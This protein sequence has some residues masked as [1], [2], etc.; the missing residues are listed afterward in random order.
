MRLL[1]SKYLQEKADFYQAFM[2]DG[3]T[4]KE[5]CNLEVE[6][7]FNESDHIHIGALVQSAG[8]KVRVIY[9]DRGESDKVS[10][11]D[12]PDENQSQPPDIHLLYR[13]GHYDILYPK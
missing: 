9:L 12:F 2:E 10:T 4:V 13:P 6:P 11:H 1:T 5:F 7:M 8:I 3:K